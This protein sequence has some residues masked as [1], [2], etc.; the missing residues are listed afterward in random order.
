L[1]SPPDGSHVD[2]VTRKALLPSELVTGPFTLAEA[3]RAGLDR[4]HLEGA[5][6]RRLGPRVY[7]RS[8]L[9]ALPLIQFAAALLRVPEGAVF[10]GLS[11]AWLHGLD[12]QPCS[13]I[14]MT[15]PIDAGISG[16]SGLTLRRATLSTAEVTRV[17]DIPTTSMERTLADLS[18]HL[19]ITEAVVLTDAATHLGLAS[20]SS[21]TVAAELAAG[22]P[23]VRALRRV[24]ELT[25]PA[26]ESPMESRLRMLLVLAGLPQPVAQQSIYDRQGRI[27][28]RPDL[29]YPARRIGLEYDGTFHRD[30]LVD[31]N[32]RQNRLLAEGIRLL[33]FTAGDIYRRPGAVVGQVRALLA[34][35]T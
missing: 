30:N 7:A 6:W 28:G 4:W 1:C 31:D 14:E 29:Y 27:L 12:V 25:E 21:L 24:I 13:P 26:A 34:A 23:G 9:G 16:R 33:R 35:P 10:S 18:A 22:R 8:E 5:A 17:R 20:I 11:A 32:R 15:I 2:W 3:R 19:S